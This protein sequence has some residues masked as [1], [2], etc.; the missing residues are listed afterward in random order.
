MLRRG[1]KYEQYFNGFKRNPGPTWRTVFLTEFRF[2]GARNMAPWRSGYAG[3]C[4]TPY[5]GSIP[6]VASPILSASFA[7]G[8]KNECPE[9]VEGRQLKS[10]GGGTGRRARLKPAWG[11]P[12]EFDSPPEHK[13]I[14]MM[15]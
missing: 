3:V 7:S 4:K 2:S 13:L 15:Q 1:L 5:A 14:S 9:L 10:S 6:A 11:N 8:Y 12:W